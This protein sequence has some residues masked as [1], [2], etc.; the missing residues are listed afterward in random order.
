MTG[1][2]TS[3]G[4]RRATTRRAGLLA[5]A[6]L[7]VLAGLPAVAASGH[8][9]H[10]KAS[11]VVEV[12]RFH[13]T[14]VRPGYAKAGGS[15]TLPYAEHLG[16]A[17][18]SKSRL[19]FTMDAD[20]QDPPLNPTYV[21]A[22]RLGNLRPAAGRGSLLNGWVS[23]HLV[24]LQHR[25]LT[26]AVSAGG[27]YAA[28]TAVER[29][30]A[31]HGVPKQADVTPVSLGASQVVVGLAEGPRPNLVFALSVAY[32]SSRPAGTTFGVQQVPGSVQLSL[33]R[34][35]HAGVIWT[36]QLNNCDLPVF[37]NLPH[38]PAPIGYVAA[39]RSVDIG[40]I[41]PPTPIAST[42]V[43]PPPIPSGVG[44]VSLGDRVDRPQF[45][46]AVYALPGDASSTPSGVWAP[47]LDRLALTV[48]AVNGLAAFVFDG[49]HNAWVGSVKL[50]DQSPAAI[51]LDP[52]H[53]R[54]Y[55]L[56]K[57]ADLGHY[58]A[59]LVLSDLAVTPV[60]VGHNFS[61]FA[62][63]S[64]PPGSPPHG[65][66]L[67][68]DPATGRL[69]LYYAESPTFLVAHDAMPH[70]VA[71][72]PAD[73]DANTTNVVERPGVTGATYS[74][75]AQ[76]YGSIVRQVG[77]A[78]NLVHNLVN[79]TPPLGPTRE[80]QAS[81]LDNLSIGQTGAQAGAVA[82]EPD[83][84]TFQQIPQQEVG[85]KTVGGWPYQAVACHS[86]DSSRT[87]WNASGA[88]V[89]CTDTGATAAV[90]AGSSSASY[91]A[92][93]GG[94][95]GAAT[96][97][98]SVAGSTLSATSSRD[99]KRGTVT[100]ITSVA[101][102]ITLLGGLLRIGE[103]SATADA[104]AHGRPHTA[105]SR[106]SRTLRDVSLDGKPLCSTNCDPATIAEQVNT[107]LAGHVLISFPAPDH[108]LAK[109][110]PGG[111]QAVVQRDTYS[112]V[113]ERT[114]N[115]QPGNR[116]EV[117][118][119]EATIFEDGTQ[120]SRTVVYLAGVEAEAHY[121][122]YR[123]GQ[124]GSVAPGQPNSPNVGKA[125]GALTP[126]GPTVTSPTGDLAGTPTVAAP[127]DI[128]GMLHHGWK[129]LLAGA[130]DVFRLLGVWVVLLAPV[131]LSARRWLLNRRHE[132]THV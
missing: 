94:S 75:S 43:P 120:P 54:F 11:G 17:V 23:T 39:R 128:G 65:D 96:S 117:P 35:G 106:F 89:V 76:G 59:G 51:G 60:D 130:G 26:V 34:L 37:G 81:Y 41:P 15:Q 90:A 105:G 87:G 33:I 114:L 64:A 4:R 25:G 68:V 121:G 108:G 92:G 100:T 86:G 124:P 72:K 22:Y 5:A 20:P 62:T 45:G 13:P 1:G 67:A 49:R 74:G 29:V 10:H 115:D 73:P 83:N 40:C 61:Q 103:V 70:Y 116:I 3:A 93:A 84:A 95:S 12:G 71:P 119:L 118:G 24:D 78:T 28:T 14:L 7:S 109:G 52:V 107:A 30:V 125:P 112:A 9:S 32:Q 6:G 55:S 127:T 19:L 88:Q 113:D 99:S 63:D 31:V 18:D 36:H 98:V 97:V 53:S 21:A 58:G 46:F 131:Y 111:Y 91:A 8:A 27:V 57:V 42:T 16:L 85:A 102:G 79:G 122:I 126:G 104:H 80:L 132:V 77:G 44:V 38:V 129:L 110:S 82:V 48:N 47:R 69:F 123:L 2:D 66:P 101:R 56:T 50:S